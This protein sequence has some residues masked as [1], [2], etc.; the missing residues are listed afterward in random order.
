M[1]GCSRA[2]RDSNT[3][4]KKTVRF[5]QCPDLLKKWLGNGEHSWKNC[6][7]EEE[8]YNCIENQ[9]IIYIYTCINSRTHVFMTH[10]TVPGCC[11]VSVLLLS[12]ASRSISLLKV[13]TG[14]LFSYMEILGIQVKFKRYSF[15]CIILSY[16][17][18]QALEAT[19]S[20]L[21]RLIHPRISLK[22]VQ[23]RNPCWSFINKV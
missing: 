9:N 15:C 23:F 20:P 11:L 2:K 1:P 13:W 7:G 10:F 22:Y 12:L 16:H 6:V 17:Q 4:W 19:H 14:I 18:V 3:A 8:T 5:R 21:L